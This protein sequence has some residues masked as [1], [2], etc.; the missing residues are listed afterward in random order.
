MEKKFLE[1]DNMKTTDAIL[2]VRELE[3]KDIP[4]IVGYWM[5]ADEKHLL[6]MGVDISKMPKEEDLSAMLHAQLLLPLDKKKSY[7]TIW[8]I[9]GEPVGHCNTNP[10]TFG[11]EANMHLH[12]WS[13][14]SRRKGIGSTL[15][16]MSLNYFFKNLQLKRLLCEPYALNPAPNKT[17][18]KAGF[19]FIKEYIT[20]PGAFNFEQPVKQWEMTHEKFISINKQER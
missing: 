16:K 12:L 2:S 20:T 1:N 8:Q 17:L 3:G 19:D 14:A 5:N 11:E 9:N 7:C 13:S 10:T 4:L 6:G 18:E 15:L